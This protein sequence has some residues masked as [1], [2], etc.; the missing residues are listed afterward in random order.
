MRKEEDCE[1]WEKFLFTDELMSDELGIRIKE[2]C[3]KTDQSKNMRN[4]PAY[5]KFIN[6]KRTERE[7]CLFTLYAYADFRLPKQF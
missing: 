6:W 7:V 4:G 5:D 1:P 3:V 2:A